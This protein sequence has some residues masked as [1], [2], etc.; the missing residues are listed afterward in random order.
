[1]TSSAIQTHNS[2]PVKVTRL[3]SWLK[4]EI[5]NAARIKE[6]KELFR[7]GRLHTVC[8]SAHCPNMGKCWGQ[9]VATFM[10]LG[11]VCTRACRFC[12]IAAGRP[13]ELDLAEPQN[14][15]LAVKE[16]N[17]RYV[18]VTSVARDDLK[19]EGAGQFAAT[20]TAIRQIMPQTKIE[21]LVP[22][23]SGKLE[24][25]KVV[26]DA[27]PE[28][29]SQNLETVRRLSPTVRPQAGY[30]RTLS[31]LK[32]YK[33]LDASIFTKSSLMVGLGET[34]SEIKEAMADLAKVGCDILTIG[35]YLAPS[36]MK[37]H[38]PVVE[39]VS[40][41]QFKEYELFGYELGFKHVMS[42]PLVRSSFIAEE[43]YQ[44]CMQAIGK[45]SL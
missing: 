21:V 36:Q 26:V 18:V 12:A 14:V 30:E 2:F 15:A 42:G 5:P 11:D 37:R 45:N 33:D 35:Q 9:G 19:D 23:F 39:F 10:I 41:Q 40:P 34:V 44:G 13:T 7:G 1:M 6:M 17:L 16:L 20:I 3:P 28:V 4:Q 27:K 25:L 22:D 38:C 43:G 31:V 24:S 32:K 8:E 29:I